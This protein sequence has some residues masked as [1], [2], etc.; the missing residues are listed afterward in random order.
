[1]SN[2]EG[3]ILASGAR[4]TT[5]T[6]ADLYNADARGVTV[7]LDVTAGSTLLLT[8]TIEG[9]DPASGKYVVLLSGA[10]VTG[11]STNMYTVH[12]AITETANIDAAVCVPFTWRVKVTHNNANS[13]TYSV[14][15]SLLG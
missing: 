3:V 14:G 8:L 2:T 6:S 1:M 4:T 15:Y 13:A 9:K 5:Q 7:W 10:S 11:V 12:P